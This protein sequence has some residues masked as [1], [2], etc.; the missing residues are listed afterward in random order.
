MTNL[1]KWLVNVLMMIS[2]VFVLA[3]CGGGSGGGTTYTPPAEAADAD[4][5]GVA[6][7]DD[8][9]PD[10]P[11]GEEVNSEGCSSSQ[12]DADA[13]GVA[14]SIDNCP[15]Y[16]NDELTLE[17]LAD[18]TD[19]DVNG[20]G[21]VCDAMPLTYSAA[22]YA[23]AGTTDGVSYTGQ[24]AR[25]VLQLQL[26]AAMEA[27]TERSG[28]TATIASE[29]SFFINGDGADTTNHGFT[30]KNGAADGSDVTP[31]PTYGDISTGKNLDGKIAG[32]NGEGGGESGKLI[33]DE[34]FGWSTGLDATPI[35]IELALYYIAKIAAE[36]GDGVEP[37]IATVADAAVPIGTPQIDA[38]GL[39]YRQLLQKFLS[40][41]VNFS[42]GTND[43]LMADFANMLGEEKDGA[44]Y[45]AGAHDFDEAFG[46]YGAARN[47]NDFTDDEAAGKGGRDEFGNGYN[48]VNGDGLIDVRSEYVFGHAQNCAK[49]DRN[50]DANDVAY[51]DYSKDAMD[52][53]LIGRRILENAEQAEE[54]TA[55]ASEALQA[56]IQ[57]ASLTWE[58][59]IA[60]TVVHYINDVITDMG[61]FSDGKFADLSNF[62]TLAKHWGEMKGFALGLQFSPKSPFR[63]GS[64]DGI[65][66]DSLKTILTLMGDAPVLADGSQGGVAF[67]TATAQDAIDKY[68]A[69]L[70]SAR[71]TLQ[72]AYGFGAE[73]TAS[74]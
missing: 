20:S 49:R 7:G 70:T 36:A 33:G 62:T 73:V 71:D 1:G 53:F 29:L 17:Q 69:D 27:L 41:A 6:D 66:L 2:L 51:Y 50:K 55:A 40:V 5:D 47:M 60:A 14:D 57:I 4:G 11:A 18:Q 16:T 32:G 37:T 44:G 39:H 28:E 30:V 38:N 59:C 15:D 10:T 43:Y 68:I 26:V 74:W 46:Y 35:P 45:S 9:C 58:K 22:G 21:D 24:T 19:S 48:D 34:F 31:G 13:D 25:Q 54:L 8:S 56:Q 63:D 3:A 67:T 64:V 65:N 42:Q 61:G 12:T 23:G 72:T 52:A